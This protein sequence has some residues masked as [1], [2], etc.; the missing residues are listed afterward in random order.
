MTDDPLLTLGWLCRGSPG[1]GVGRVGRIFQL[2]TSDADTAPDLTAVNCLLLAFAKRGAIRQA[3]EAFEAFKAGKA[4]R[5]HRE[6]PPLSST[7][8][9]TGTVGGGVAGKLRHDRRHQ[10]HVSSGIRV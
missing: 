5:L 10:W 1:D 2:M 6:A 8:T 7:T 4:W 3:L 9:I